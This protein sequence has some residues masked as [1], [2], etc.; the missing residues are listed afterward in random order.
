[1]RRLI[2][3]GYGAFVGYRKGLVL[4]KR[5]DG[6]ESIPLGNLD[7]IVIATRGAAISSKLLRV[8]LKNRVEVSILSSSGSP[9][10]KVFSVRRSHVK[11]RLA[12]VE[13]RKN[14]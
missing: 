7:Q 8:C 9:L 14:S 10:G 5:K 4:V 13:A 11:L 1:M 6:N 2:I 12:Q 3:N